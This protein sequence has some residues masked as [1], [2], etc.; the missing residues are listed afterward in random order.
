MFLCVLC[1]KSLTQR[2]AYRNVNAR[3][4]LLTL[5]AT[6]DKNVKPS[7]AQSDTSRDYYNEEPIGLSKRPKGQP[8]LLKGGIT[9][10][11]TTF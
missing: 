10:I 6:L 3:P 5:I 8:L 11:N 9:E 7:A 4:S 1:N 2:S